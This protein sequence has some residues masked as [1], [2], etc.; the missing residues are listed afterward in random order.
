MP[1]NTGPP[2]LWLVAR[3]RTSPMMRLPQLQSN[4]ASPM[5]MCSLVTAYPRLEAFLASD[6]T[7]P[8]VRELFAHVAAPPPASKPRESR[9][10]KE[11]TTTLV[12][13]Q[14]VHPLRCGDA[15]SGG[16]V[17]GPGGTV[18]ASTGAVGVSGGAG[19]FSAPPGSGP[20]MSRR[21]GGY[22]SVIKPAYAATRRTQR[23]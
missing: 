23:F 18:P 7:N 14:P 16:T 20:P 5:L 13:R 22:S 12:I 15:D 6:V 3:M 19:S 11:P 1:M 8:F 4:T 9:Q 10:T 21:N 17:G 2:L